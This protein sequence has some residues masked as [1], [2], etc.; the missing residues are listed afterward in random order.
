MVKSGPLGNSTP[1]LRRRAPR[2]V[3]VRV[4]ALWAAVVADRLLGEPP[5]AAHPVALFGRAMAKVEERMWADRRARGLAYTLAGAGGAAA[6]GA[7]LP[8]RSPGR[9]GVTVTLATYLA[10]AATALARAATAVAG[11]LQREDLPAARLLLRS[12]VG[13]ETAAL[14]QA[15]V[16][17][18]TVESLAEN[19]VDAVTAP[20]LW[21][22]CLGAPGVLAYRA[23]NTLDAMVGHRS[24]RYE[25][26]GWAAARA[27]DVAN[28]IPARVTALAVAVVRPHRARAVLRAVRD[29]AP[30]HPSPNAG[31]VEAAFAAA[32]G[33]ELGGSNDYAGRIEVRP[34]LGAGEVPAE[35]HIEEAC[36]LS[37]HAT[38]AICVALSAVAVAAGSR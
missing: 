12:L 38:L 25:R 18:A 14:D 19:T 32:M 35:R 28:W 9:R 16:V 20:L 29:Q 37:R 11:A 24:P 27:D 10:I 33:I 8:R 17:R 22:M 4:V 2:P 6:L 5:A 34:V 7:A 1:M 21:A 31:V 13:R 36:R 3:M 26:F 15:E 30:A 23:V